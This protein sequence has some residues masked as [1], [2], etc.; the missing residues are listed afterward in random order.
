LFDGIE[1]LHH[2][3]DTNES[4]LTGDNRDDSRASAEELQRQD[5]SSGPSR[6]A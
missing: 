4:G 6:E 3:S 5:V 2:V 1:M